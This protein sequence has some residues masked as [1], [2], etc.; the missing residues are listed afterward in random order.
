MKKENIWQKAAQNFIWDKPYK[1]IS[2]A[3]KTG[4]KK[5]FVAGK[6]NYTKTIFEKNFALGNALK[7]AVVFY[8]S[9]FQ[10]KSYTYASLLN[11]TNLLASY[12]EQKGINK[13][14][15]VL[16]LTGSKKEQVFLILALLRLGIQFGVLYSK[17]PPTLINI[18]I[19][20][21]KATH[22]ISNKKLAKSIRAGKASFIKLD[23]VPQKKAA[24]VIRPGSVS[25]DFSC[26]LSFS[27]GT[28]GEKP[29][30]F[31]NGTA[32][33]LIG[34]DYIIQ[35]AIFNGLKDDYILNTLNFTFGN[36]PIIA[37][38]IMPLNRGGKIIFLDFNYRL[39]DKSIMKILEKE[40]VEMVI[41]SP[42]FFE[43]PQNKY[44]SPKIKNVLIA[45]QKVSLTVLDLIIKT[46]PGACLINIVGSQEA[47]AYLI[48]SFSNKN[49]K[50]LI[51]VL[52]PL[53]G[54]EYKIIKKEIFIKDTWPCL[55]PPLNN[56]RSYLKRW[57]GRFFGT[58][59]LVKKTK[60]GLE[61]VGRSDQLTKYRGR[62]INLEYL[63]N[64]LESQPFVH[65]AK[66]LIV[67]NKSKSELAVFLSLKQEH[68]NF[69]LSQLKNLIKKIVDAR[70]GSYAKLSKIVFVKEFPT[71]ASGKV[72]EKIL[73]KKYA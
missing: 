52:K 50:N 17:F 11:Q 48:R 3:P 33:C 68:Q 41:S 2:Q 38:L 4:P 1:K 54:L 57:R 30:I 23:N 60:L 25:S 70:F 46:F 6:L 13:K 73:L 9:P 7:E 49:S 35:A 67:H 61:I 64:I 26:F 36:Y 71:S 53:L 29:K 15:R 42:P 37:G 43:I 10:K 47:S 34:M 44:S 62:Q 72:M 20:K 18:L 27:S 66:C 65:K 39:N 24:P 58:G 51:N 31:L 8:K 16:I 12:L 40:G 5:W 56:K 32:G 55:A 14:S 28:T 21:S 69:S 63:E 19:H 59:D 45:G 22:I